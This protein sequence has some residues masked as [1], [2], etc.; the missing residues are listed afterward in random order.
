MLSR[1][2]SQFTRFAGAIV[3]AERIEDSTVDVAIEADSVDTAN[4]ERDAHLRANDF[5]DSDAHPQLRFRST[6]VEWAAG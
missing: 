6:A 4:P 2:R 3:V 1:T 5:L